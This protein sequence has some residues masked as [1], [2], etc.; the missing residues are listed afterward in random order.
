MPKKS[1]PRKKA[2]PKRAKKPAVP[3]HLKK[4][5]NECDK[6][7]KEKA[8]VTRSTRISRI[9]SSLRCATRSIRST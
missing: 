7:E 9:S 5:L 3:T 8:A 6:L 1:S 2:A 4:L